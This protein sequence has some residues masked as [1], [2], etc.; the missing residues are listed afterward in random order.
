L[1]ADRDD[2]NSSIDESKRRIELGNYLMSE[3]SLPLPDGL[4]SPALAM[5]VFIYTNYIDPAVA[6]KME[7]TASGSGSAI[8]D[9]ELRSQILRYF[10]IADRRKRI[11]DYLNPKLNDL[12][13]Q[14]EMLGVS[15]Y[16]RNRDRLDDVIRNPEVRALMITILSLSEFAVSY[17]DDYSELNRQL[18]SAVEEALAE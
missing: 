16:E 9:A 5:E 18:T 17:V 13:S 12:I 15:P 1:R 10:A 6:T 11:N 3:G 14:M 4:E 2:L 8:Q 7:I